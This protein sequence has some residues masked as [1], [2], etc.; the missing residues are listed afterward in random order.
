[1]FQRL[2]IFAALDARCDFRCPPVR[3][4]AA[5]NSRWIS[6]ADNSPPI[7]SSRESA[8]AADRW[9]AIFSCGVRAP[10]R[11]ARASAIFLKTSVSCVAKPLTVS[12][13]FGIRSARRCRATSTCDHG[14]FTASRCVT[15]SLRR[16]RTC[17]PPPRRRPPAPRMMIRAAFTCVLLFLRGGPPRRS[18][19]R[20]PSDR[21][22][23]NR[24]ARKSRG[25]DALLPHVEQF[26]EGRGVDAEVLP[27]ALR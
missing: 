10:P 8:P 18:R 14:A 9:P 27:R 7:T 16:S 12:T 11:A 15:R 13:R 4:A 21:M 26:F 20:S 17:R 2:V 23:A 1:M 3:P 25:F 24:P 6:A 22:P 5:E 19:W